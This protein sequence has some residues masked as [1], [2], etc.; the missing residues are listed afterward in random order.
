MDNIFCL[1]YVLLP[2]FMLIYIQLVSTKG[3][4]SSG[5]TS[6]ASNCVDTIQSVAMDDAAS[7]GTEVCAPMHD[8]F[9]STDV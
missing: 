2:N 6:T 4:Y 7:E 9:L 1:P 3:D 8:M 5:A